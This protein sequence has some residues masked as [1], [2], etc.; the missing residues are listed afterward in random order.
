MRRVWEGE[1]VRVVE[2]LQAKL[3]RGAGTIM[4]IKESA[5]ISGTNP[6]SGFIDY[7]SG[8]EV[9]GVRACS[10]EQIAERRPGKLADGN[11]I[12]QLCMALCRYER[13]K[14]KTRKEKKMK[15][16]WIL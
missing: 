13:G 7:A 15:S 6:L 14:R 4:N 11:V 10:S 9:Q 16:P 5:H 2:S 3:A 8:E 12:R 1:E